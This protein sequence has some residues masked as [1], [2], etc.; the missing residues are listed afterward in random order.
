M[1]SAKPPDILRD[2]DYLVVRQ[3]W[4]ELP[5]NCVVCDA[6]ESG[7]LRLK[8]RKA[9]KLCAVFGYFGALVYFTVP[10]ARL[11]AGFCQGHRVRER[12]AQRVVR[13]MLWTAL[14]CILIAIYFASPEAI[15]LG[16]VTAIL[17]VNFAF[18][19]EIVRRKL[20]KAVH[21][22]RHF[23]WLANVSPS[24]LSQFPEVGSQDNSSPPSETS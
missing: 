16:V 5:A 4:V 15:V 11:R 17:L 6:K 14:A 18:I 24:F 19:Y 21:A 7:R 3:R 22:D 8:I 1:P 9:S 23:I 20:L 13:S 12:R 10:V 2:G